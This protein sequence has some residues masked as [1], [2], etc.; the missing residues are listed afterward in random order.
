VS[1]EIHDLAQARAAAAEGRM[2][3]ARTF[4]DC[5]HVHVVVDDREME[6]ECRDCKAK[7]NPIELLLKYTRE[8]GQYRAERDHL[9]A[10]MAIAEQKLTLKCPCCSRMLR[11]EHKSG[12]VVA[13]PVRVEPG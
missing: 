12:T 10:T 1:G 4:K 2:V 3:V 7:L 9:N 8:G 5:R 13:R 11:L 6:A